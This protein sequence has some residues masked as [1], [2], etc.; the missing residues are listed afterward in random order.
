MARH[1]PIL[2]LRRALADQHHVAEL[3]AALGQALASRVAHRPPRPQTALQ[4]TA[5]RPAALDEQREVDRLVRALHATA[6]QHKGAYRRSPFAESPS[7][8]P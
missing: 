2:G 3:A 4:L 5:Q 6:L 8:Q 7:D 1:C